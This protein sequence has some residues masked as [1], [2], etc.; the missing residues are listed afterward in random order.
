M[1][2]DYYKVLGVEKN[3]NEKDIKKAYRKL[4]KQ[5]HPDANPN[6]PNAEAKFKEI[7]EA[8][9]VLSDTEKRAQYD[10]FGSDFQQWGGGMGGNPY[11][12]VQDTPFGDIFETL[13]GGFG[14]G[15]GGRTQQGAGGFGGI[16][17][18]G[19]NLE[20]PVTITLQEAYQGTTRLITKG[21]RKVRVNI[22]AGADNGTKVRLAGEGAPG[23]GG[24]TSGDLYLIVEVQPD[25]QFER[26]G[27]NLSVEVKVDMFTAMLGGE[28][29]IPTMERPVNLRIPAGTQSGRKFRLTGKGMPRMRQSGEYGDLYVRILITVPEHL[30]PEQRHLAEQFR[31]V[32]G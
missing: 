9:E 8:Y 21:E 10:R 16:P 4:A 5:Y 23:F 2:K 3:A 12:N 32:L 30:T 28:V 29:A 25:N 19:Q 24:G 1:A 31:E 27:D 17:Q 20:Q 26:Q 6:N 14:R 18:T 15:R 7:S 11:T 22:P 13:F